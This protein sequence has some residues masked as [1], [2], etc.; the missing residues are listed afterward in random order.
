[1]RVNRVVAIVLSLLVIGPASGGEPPS[2]SGAPQ[3]RAGMAAR[4]RAEFLHAWRAYERY[5]WGHDELRPLSKA[6]RDWQAEPLLVTPVDAL[7]TLILI[8]FADE[9]NGS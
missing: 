4:V 2:S 5:A 3:D 1:M 7:D 8:G 6:A 9:A